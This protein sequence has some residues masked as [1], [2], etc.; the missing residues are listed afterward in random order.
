MNR[1]GGKAPATFAEIR[2]IVDLA[3]FAIT[4]GREDGKAAV[5]GMWKS[6]SS[7][8]WH[9]S[10]RKTVEASKRRSVNMSKA[11]FLGAFFA[12]RCSRKPFGGS[13]KPQRL[14]PANT[15]VKNYD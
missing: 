6:R 3:R 8:T 10:P 1:E 12:P 9:G 15:I 13:S 2:A 11:P 14:I 4:M 7:S 5:A